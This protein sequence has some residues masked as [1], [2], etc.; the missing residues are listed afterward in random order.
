M[1][2]LQMSV[3]VILAAGVAIS[4]FAA[5]ETKPNVLFIMSDD[6]NTALSGYGHP[7]CKTPNL[8]RLARTGVSFTRAYCQWPICG[9]SRASIMSGQ[10]P[11]ANGVRGNG[12]KVNQDRVTLPR[13]FRNN[14]Y[15]VGRVGKIYHL[16][17]PGEVMGGLPGAD[18]APSWDYTYNLHAMETLTPGKAEDLTG[19]DSTSKYPEL[20][21]KWKQQKPGVKKLMIPGNHQGS[22]QV[23]VETADDS[24]LLADGMSAGKAVELLRQR[25]AKKQPFFLAVGFLRP[26]APYVAPERDFSQYDYREM[27]VPRVPADDYADIPAQ[28]RGQDM[29]PDGTKRRKIL[30]GYYGSVSYMDRMVGH[31]LDELDRLKLRDNTI[32]TFVSDHGYLLGEHNLWRKNQLW[33][34]ATRV[35]LIVSVPGKRSKGQICEH[36]VEL[37]DLYPTLAQLAGLPGDSGGQGISL[38]PLLEDPKQGVLS[39]KDALIQV[40]NGYGLRQG[41]WAYMWYPAA[42]RSPAGF[43]LYDMEKDPQQYHNLAGNPE[44][45]GIRTHLHGR[46]MERIESARSPGT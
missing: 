32:V 8:D 12:G 17:V 20:R 24:S 2:S 15:W 10:Y 41:N 7:Q 28:A 44:Y 38:T 18:H 36:L 42:R 13:L 35:P 23:V 39:R 46:L 33:E 29:Q 22:D 31:L 4:V 1:K 45:K 21:K 9:P 11:D 34:E 43:M 6:L 5:E 19:P 26:H 40:R 25:A 14:G 37:V 3:S 27:T 16:G 30:R